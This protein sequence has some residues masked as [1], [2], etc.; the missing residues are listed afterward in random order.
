MVPLLII[1]MRIHIYAQFW[2]KLAL[3]SANSENRKKENGRKGKFEGAY[4]PVADE[5]SQALRA[6]FVEQ[7]PSLQQ[8]L[9][10]GGAAIIESSRSLPGDAPCFQLHQ[11]LPSSSTRIFHFHSSSQN[12]Q[13]F[14]PQVGGEIF[15]TCVTE[16]SLTTSNKSPRRMP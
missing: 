14:R 10:K 2:K 12:L 3:Q 15:P 6:V 11:I 5:R 1:R 16:R 7:G 4:A 8:F 13:T 9:R